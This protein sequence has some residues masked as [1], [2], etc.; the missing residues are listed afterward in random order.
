MTQLYEPPVVNENDKLGA[1]I[2]V[3]F[4]GDLRNF[5]VIN[6]N[7]KFYWAVA[8]S[9]D[10]TAVEIIQ[11]EISKTIIVSEAESDEV[12]LAAVCDLQ[13]LHKH[14]PETYYLSGYIAAAMIT[15]LEQS[16][17]HDFAINQAIRNL[18]DVVVDA[19]MTSL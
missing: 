16:S 3:N 1:V 6:Q 8:I 17:R 15:V 12:A 18:K 7:D 4:Q 19:V 14:D 10:Y 9:N 2:W 13:K 11:M 5:F